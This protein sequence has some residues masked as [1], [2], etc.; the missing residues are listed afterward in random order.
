MP[1]PARDH[2]SSDNTEEYFEIRVK[3]HLSPSWSECF[4]GLEV[5]N[6]NSGET[7]LIG[8]VTDQAELHGVLAN[9]RDLNLVLISVT[10]VKTKHLTRDQNSGVQ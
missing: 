10:R 2:R 1:K 8:P 9:I 6:T 4:G 5:V 7:I 3:G